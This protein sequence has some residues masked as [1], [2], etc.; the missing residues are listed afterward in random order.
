[1]LHSHILLVCFEQCVC[2]Y[3]GQR[4]VCSRILSLG[5]WSEG[6]NC[7][8]RLKE[9]VEKGRCLLTGSDLKKILEFYCGNEQFCKP[10]KSF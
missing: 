5:H 10:T 3:V 4:T 1:M 9:R 2:A 7:D 6:S 8:C